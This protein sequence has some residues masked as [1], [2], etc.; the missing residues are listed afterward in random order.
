MPILDKAQLSAILY[1]E[2]NLTAN[3]FT[4]ERLELLGI[5]AS[6]AAISL[7]NAKLFK[8]ATIDGLTGLVVPRYFHL[9]LDNEIERSR[10]FDRPVSLLMIDID[11]FKQFND[12]Y[13]HLQ[14][15]EALKSVAQLLRDNIR[16]IDVA[17][18]YGG[19]EFVLILPETNAEQALEAGEKIRRGIEA[20]C[21]PYDRSQLQVTVSIGVA[22]I[23]YHA[24]EKKSLIASADEALY[25]SKRNGKNRITVGRRLELASGIK[26]AAG[27]PVC[28]SLFVKKRE[29]AR[30]QA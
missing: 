20:Q 14:G 10:R 4:S 23:P 2:N 9:L 15:D 6:Q 18:R 27:A 19:E 26:P 3:V 25:T 24:L 28:D 11:N 13:G 8:L 16:R 7:E 21:I 5:I 17:A 29:I 12:T 30:T 1:M 22:T